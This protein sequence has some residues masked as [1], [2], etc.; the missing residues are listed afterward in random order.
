MKLKTQSFRFFLDPRWT[1][2]DAGKEIVEYALQKEKPLIPEDLNFQKK[3]Q[4]LRESNNKY[5]RL[6]SSFSYRQILSHIKS[7]A[8]REG[9]EIYHVHP[10][11]T[12]I[13]GEVKFTK[14]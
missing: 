3:K 6:R 9:I 5:G 4:T 12:T 1:I 14:R 10:A 2:G 8:F 7:K 11:Y 13:I